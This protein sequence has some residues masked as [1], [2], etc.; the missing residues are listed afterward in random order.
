MN[1]LLDSGAFS[2]WS[3]NKKI[4]IDEYI[5]FI[6]ERSSLIDHYVNLDVIGDP[7]ATLSNQKYMESKGLSPIPVFH[8]KENFSYLQYYIDNYEYVG[9]GGL[10]VGLG[11]SEIQLY[12]DQCFDLICDTKDRLPKVKAHGFGITGTDAMFR[13]P[14][15]SVDS[16]SWAFTGAFGAIFIPKYFHGSV[17]WDEIPLKIVVSTQAPSF[18]GEAEHFETFSPFEQKMI[19]NWISKNGFIFGKSEFKDSNGQKKLGPNERWGNK[20][21]TK[22]EIILEKGLCNDHNQRDRWNIK[23]FVD[24]EKN[25]PP[26]PWPFKPNKTEGFGLI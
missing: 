7:E 5:S 4:N 21:K 6:K 14:W 12:L 19:L 13:Y 24:L 26:W 11:N 1:I 23:Y 20:E 16:S 9:L 25:F 2:A 10:A 8:R 3:K 18:T 17:K 15:F 22:I